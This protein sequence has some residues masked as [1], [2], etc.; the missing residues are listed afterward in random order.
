[1]IAPGPD[2]Y[3][4]KSILFPRDSTYVYAEEPELTKIM[5]VADTRL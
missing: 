1:M 2:R 5:D 3:K 4:F